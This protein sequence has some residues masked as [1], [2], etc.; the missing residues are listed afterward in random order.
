MININK[1]TVKAIKSATNLIKY[2]SKYKRC[3][4]C[5][6]YQPTIERIE[7][8]SCA[9]NHPCKYGEIDYSDIINEGG[10]DHVKK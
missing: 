8:G 6:F 1:D 4:N 9:I 3:H 5:I 2:C 7:F 10:G